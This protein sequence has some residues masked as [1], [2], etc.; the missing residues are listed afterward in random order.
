MEEN[1]KLLISVLKQWKIILG[2]TVFMAVVMYFSTA[3]MPRVYESNATLYAGL[4]TNDGIVGS[5]ITSM[6][7][8]YTTY[9]NLANIMKSRET[10]KEVG[11]RLFAL[12]MGM[13]EPDEKILSPETFA[14]VRNIIPPELY[15]YVGE[16]DS[17]TYLNL[18]EIADTHPFL[19]NL[20][21]SPY[22]P[23]YSIAALSNVWIARIGM[24][25]L[26]MLGYQSNDRG[27]CQK[28]LEIVI[29]V[30]VQNYRKLRKGQIGKKVDYFEEAL[31]AAQAKLKRAEAKEEDFKKIYGIVDIT[32][33]T[34]IAITD[35]QELEKQISKEQETMAAAQAS[36]RQIESQM[37]TK[38]QSMRRTDIL[39]K[40]EQLSRL[41]SQLINAQMNNASSSQI[42][43]LQIQYNQLKE[44]FSNDLAESMTSS[45]AISDAASTEYLTRMLTY[46][47][48]KARLRALQA[49]K[50]ASNQQFNKHLP[51][52]DSLRR[53]QR[54]IEIC[55]KEYLAAVDERNKARREQQDQLSFSNIQIYDKPNFPMTGKN[56]RKMLMILGTVIG[57]V[58]PASFFLGRA[59]FND[60]IQTPERA[61][62]KIGL[63]CAGVMPNIEKLQNN[64]FPEMI[65]NGLSDT[66]LKSLYMI[67]YKPGQTRI[68]IIST[69]PGEGK[70]VISNMLCERLLSKGRK[71]LVVKP[72]MEAGDWS[73]V[74][75]KVDKSFY[76][77]RTED[78]VPIEKMIDAEIL[79]IE[80]PS[81]ILNDYPVELIRQFDI[82]FLV[83]KANREWLKADQAALDSF[84]RISGINPHIIL[85]EVHT[86]IVEEILGKV[87]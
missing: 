77:S 67:N 83:C 78:I 57:C 5:G 32:A 19:I 10:L 76:Q 70:S 11:L 25:D 28:T 3:K 45:G 26:I 41:A 69:R 44:D 86:D 60:A 52:Q 17:I 82:A 73:V 42:Q 49:Q 79:I 54:D 56:Q 6:Q 59:L 80:L 13:T 18:N 64:Q 33:Q 24:S 61:E 34:G 87:S 4:A 65:S 84:V 8:Q 62:K 47:E 37:G 71:C 38:G 39:H 72:Y 15:Q 2:C 16:T 53:F 35:R 63:R 43:R 50:N 58:L 20:I 30:C 66:I 31:K 40:Q 27:L 46:E 85:N 36:M 1:I 23:F 14:I 22:M 29:D 75:Y 74:S 12:H 7:M 81:L 68:L 48:S 9:D 55:L 21:N 51:L